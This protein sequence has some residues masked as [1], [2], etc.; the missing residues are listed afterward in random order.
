[1]HLWI[2]RMVIRAS[3]DQHAFDRSPGLIAVFHA[4][5]RLLA[6]RHPP[7]A[8]GSLAA[9]IPP[10][11]SQLQPQ[12]VPHQTKRLATKAEARGTSPLPPP[13]EL[14]A[15]PTRAG[16]DPFSFSKGSRREFHTTDVPEPRPP[17]GGMH[18]NTPAR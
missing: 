3:R 12:N 6:P 2:Q 11:Y 13:P 4:L 8:L 9:P 14:A 1:M 10:R 17:K 7:H 16:N 5:P 15:N 18:P